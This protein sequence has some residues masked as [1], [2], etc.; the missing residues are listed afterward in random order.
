MHP[1]PQSLG[2]FLDAA[3]FA[4]LLALAA[5]LPFELARPWFHLGG[6]E[7]TSVETLLY[8][9]LV[10]W[11]AGVVL[12]RSVAWTRVHAAVIGW[13]VTL[14]VSALLAG[15]GRD[16][17]LTFALRSAS[18]CLLFFAVADIAGTGRRAAHLV[19]ALVAGA[20]ISALAGMGEV[21]TPS[22]AS[23]LA[24]FKTQS[25]EISGFLRA[26][27]TFQYANIAAMYWEAAIGVAF[28]A[29]AWHAGA[30]GTRDIRW[31]FVAATFLFAEAIVLSASRGAWW[32][33]LAVL[34][35]L[36]VVAST[37]DR[38]MAV[39]LAVAITGFA[40]LTIA[41]A[42]GSGLLSRRLRNDEPSTWYRAR[43]QTVPASVVVRAGDVHRV[44]LVI[45]NTGTL[46]WSSTG[47]NP[48]LLS[49]WYDA[50][51]QA[52]IAFEGMRTPL[53][54]DVPTGGLVAVETL[55]YAALPPGQYRVEWD[56]MQNGVTWFSVL[57]GPTRQTPVVIEAGVPIAQLPTLRPPP[58]LE[59]LVRSPRQQLWRTAVGLWRERPLS[60]IGPDRFRHVYGERLGL[61]RFDDR[62]HASSLYV[63]TLVGQGLLGVVALGSLMVALLTAARSACAAASPERRLLAAGVAV[64][65]G[66]FF[67]HGLVDH[68][69]PFTPT[70]GLFWMLAGL[71]ASLGRR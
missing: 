50:S 39:P 14:V 13:L 30:G 51:G 2:S 32:S 9:V 44:R 40:A 5:A 27:G 22:V 8:A 38:R 19:H 56:L 66:A 64:A 26:S 67:V 58:R 42:S 23:L 47:P 60:G 37:R 53:P 21:W 6:L 12:G 49:H 4:A 65:L 41:D 20:A 68:F 43:Y 34:G 36:G 48:V 57:G 29:S 71:V 15:S 10:L 52:L 59:S 35:M 24:G 70:Y 28:A 31:T 1:Q 61:R 33:A 18:G 16:T 25:S 45:E 55:V 69:L 54:H 62:V 63:E 11:G 7:I 3:T 17:A 46:A